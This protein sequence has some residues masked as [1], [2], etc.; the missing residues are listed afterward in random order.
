MVVRGQ[1][2]R[3]LGNLRL[4]D[5]WLDA[6]D[7]QRMGQP[8]QVRFQAEQLAAEGAQLLGHGRP[9]HEP[10]VGDRNAGLR[11]GTKRPLR[12]A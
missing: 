6:D 9:Q 10:G 11:Q 5:G 1:L 3:D 12:Y 4:A 8:L 7:P 2:L